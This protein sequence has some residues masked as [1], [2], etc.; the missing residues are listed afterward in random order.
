MWYFVGGIRARYDATRCKD[1]TAGQGILVLNTAYE[2][3]VE[4]AR[5]NQTQASRAGSDAIRW[6]KD[7]AYDASPLWI[8]AHGIDFYTKKFEGGTLSEQDMF[9]SEAQWP[10]LREEVYKGLAEF[11]NK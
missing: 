5:K 7:H 3:L 9:V 6:D 8:C 4:F 10:S 1:Q 11:L 2:N